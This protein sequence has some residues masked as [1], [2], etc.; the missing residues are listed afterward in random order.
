[1]KSKKAEKYLKASL[2]L[3]LVFW[4][5][6]AVSYLFTKTDV[7]FLIKSLVFLE[8]VF[9]VVAL[10]GVVKKNELIGNLAILGLSLNIVLAITDEVGIADLTALVLSLIALIFLIKAKR[11]ARRK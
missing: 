3:N 9:F 6:I 8:P 11:E 7:G 4:L 10:W 2:I 1:M 5:F